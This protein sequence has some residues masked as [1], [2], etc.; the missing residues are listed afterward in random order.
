MEIKFYNA[1]I[2]GEKI[3]DQLETN[4]LRANGNIQ[5][6]VTGQKDDY[7]TGCLLH[8]P[9]FEEHYKMIGQCFF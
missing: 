6:I 4:D 8:Y 5:K 2:D 3:F 1:I 7:T 9:Y